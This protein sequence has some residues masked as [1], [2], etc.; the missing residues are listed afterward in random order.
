MEQLTRTYEMLY[1]LPITAEADEIKQIKSKINEILTKL[2]ATIV[3]EEEIGKRKLAYMIKR[4]RHGYYI[5][6]TF[7]AQPAS[8]NLIN[9]QIKLMPEILRHRIVIKPQNTQSTQRTESQPNK[10][11]ST[12]DQE[13]GDQTTKVDIEE[14]DKK[15]DEL[16]SEDLTEDLK[17]KL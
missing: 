10:S 11:E 7:N 8:I 12:T 17:E 3:T 14:L 15:I 16:L 9:H 4:A 5:L 2:Q 1:F 6:T 13:P